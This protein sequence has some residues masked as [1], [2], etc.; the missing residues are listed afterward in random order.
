MSELPTSWLLV[1]LKAIANVQSGIGFPPEYQGIVAGEIGFYKVGDIS[2]A[3]ESSAGQLQVA[4]NYVSLKVATKLG[5][6]LIPAGATVFAKIGEAIHLNRRGF[7]LTECLIDNNVMAVKACNPDMDFYI[8]NYFRSIDFS[9]LARSTTV[10]SLRKGDIEELLVPVPPVGEQKRIADKLDALLMQVDACRN[11][12]DKIPGIIKRFRQ[13]VLAATATG[14]MTADWRK[15]N[16]LLKSRVELQLIIA[17]ALPNDWI[18]STPELLKENKRYSLAIGPFG[19]SLMVK[20]YQVNG[21]PLIFVR[22]IRSR[23]F[24]DERTKFISEEKATELIAHKVVP[25]DL[26]ITKMGDPPGDTA[27][28]PTN[29]IAGIITSD[30]IKLTLALTAALPKYIALIIESPQFRKRLIEITAGVAQQKISLSRF[31]NFPLPVAPIEEQA[32]IVRRVEA[33]FAFADRLEACY[34]AARAQVENLTPALLAKAFRGELV[35]QDPNDEPASALLARI[36]DARAAPE[37]VK[38]PR[39]SKA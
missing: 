1:P 13:A 6:R 38:K 2:R 34:T 37:K 28:Y 35:P 27:I 17:E 22:D 36:R 29:R 5:G 21:V 8:Y 7:T 11:R 10:P 31:R 4:R 12:L 30:C 24:G 16:P 19:S 18:W 14:Q 3:V 20:D 26:L 25:G 23:R 33:L 39:A 32:E 15:L 9:N